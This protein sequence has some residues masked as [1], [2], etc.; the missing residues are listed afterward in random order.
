MK[1]DL[2]GLEEFAIP[3]RMANA[4]KSSTDAAKRVYK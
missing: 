1:L 4:R 2:R 3:A